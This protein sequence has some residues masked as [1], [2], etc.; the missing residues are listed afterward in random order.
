VIVQAAELLAMAPLH[1]LEVSKLP[2]QQR[3][4]IR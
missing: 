1:E 4:R 3:L 2:D